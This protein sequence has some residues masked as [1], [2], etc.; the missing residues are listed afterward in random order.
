LSKDG[1]GWTYLLV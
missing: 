1:V